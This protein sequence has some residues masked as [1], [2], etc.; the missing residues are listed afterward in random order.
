[1]SPCSPS[2]FP[3]YCFISVP[4]QRL[5]CTRVWVIPASRWL[6]FGETMKKRLRWKDKAD[7]CLRGRVCFYVNALLLVRLCLEVRGDY[8]EP[9]GAEDE[10]EK[11]TY[12]H[13]HMQ[14]NRLRSVTNN[15][16]L[17]MS[18]Y[19]YCSSISLINT[20]WS[21]VMKIR[22]VI[23]NEIQVLLLRSDI[24]AFSHKW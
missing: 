1:M 24:T 23:T 22:R 11:Q 4:A 2:E 10:R 19:T 7:E 21:A 13:T 5:R 8:W 17:E 20:S 15:N 3:R 16:L 9:R 18:V 6:F 14:Q 12:T